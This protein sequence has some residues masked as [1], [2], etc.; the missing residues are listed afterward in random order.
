MRRL[1]CSKDGV[2]RTARQLFVKK[3]Q[4]VVYLSLTLP[5]YTL[6]GP[7]AI[8]VEGKYARSCDG[9]YIS[10]IEAFPMGDSNLSYILLRTNKE[11]KKTFIDASDNHRN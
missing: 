2:Q 1:R 5:A 3:L 10:L 8:F 6:R 4:Q 9:G 11:D 7:I